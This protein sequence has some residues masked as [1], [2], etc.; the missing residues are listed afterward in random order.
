MSP[1]DLRKAVEE[2]DCV[3]A[4]G[5]L[6]TDLSTGIFT[7]RIDPAA[8]VIIGPEGVTV[9]DRF[10]GRIDMK[11]C[12]EVLA[13]MVGEVRPDQR[14]LPRKSELLPYFAERGRKITME[15]FASCI[16]SF[17]DDETVLIAEAGDPLFG[18]L[19]VTVQG[20]AGFM[21]PAYYASLGFAV[22]AAIGVQF[23]APERRPLALVG[24]GSFQ[25]TG[26]EISTALRYGLNPI[27]VVL[28]NSGYGTFRPMIDGRFNDLH[29]WK[30]A[31]ITE[32]MGGGQ[33]YTAVT[34]DQLAGA[35]EEGRKN[36]SSPT[37]IDVHFD[38]YDVSPRLRQLTEKL[39]TKTT[40]Q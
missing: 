29:P 36:I 18:A 6:V 8:V 22:P 27:I 25:M 10:A 37:V 28:N 21:S 34:E 35:L 33:G 24:D 9:S 1:D 12:I 39:R 32:V 15:R 11:P 26:V 17:M 2:A 20:A 38:R 31:A 23:A 5:P 16:N 19:D 14:L 7:Q 30:Y 13:D 3:I 4:I 40:G